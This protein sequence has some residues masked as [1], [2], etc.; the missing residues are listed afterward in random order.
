[1]HIPEKIPGHEL[2]FNP[3]G[4]LSAAQAWTKKARIK[5]EELP[6]TGKIRYVPPKRYNPSNPLP[7]EKL[8]GGKVG[9]Y[10]RFDNLWVKGP[11]RTLGQA[12]EWDVQLSRL[13][14]K[15][16]GWATRDKSHLNISLDGRITHR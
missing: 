9:Y 14:Q 4:T 16:L 3:N 10:D 7:Y 1:V 2:P 15:Q 12:F 11:S 5:Y 8:P 6:I 13:G